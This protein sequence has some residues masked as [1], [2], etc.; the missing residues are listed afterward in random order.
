[1]EALFRPSSLLV[2][3]LALAVTRVAAAPA[4]TPA[5]VATS[6]GE[7]QLLVY[8]PEEA[9]RVRGATKPL[10]L[11]M[12]GEG[13]WRAFDVLLA[14]WLAEAG[15]WVGGMDIK[16]YFEKAQDDREALSRDIRSYA[17]GLAEAAG[18]G[19][20]APMIFVGFSFGADLA[21]WIAGAGGWE[22]RLLGLV[23]IGPDSTGS[24]E[25]R[26]REMLHFSPT[27]HVFSVA[28]ALDGA[29]RFPTVFLH[30]G[31]DQVSAAPALARRPGG[32]RKLVVIPEAGHHFRG[33]EPEAR[34]AL[35]E[36]MRWIADAGRGAVPGRA[37]S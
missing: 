15:Y 21:P 8:P 4:P 29:A 35:L 22:K 5:Q 33:R 6:R 11:L 20:G 37:A 13:G 1:M 31:D 34:R 17:D 19:P 24:L 9:A 27:T 25:Y 32:L 10:V 36:A 18:A 14:G 7:L 3:A 16:P 28:D 26:I 30:G 2:A 23:M 12:S